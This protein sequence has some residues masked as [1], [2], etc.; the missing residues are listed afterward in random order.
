MKNL[1]QHIYRPFCISVIIGMACSLTALVLCSAALY[2]LQLPV[3]I[4]GIFAAF[5]LTA[6]CFVSGFVLGKQKRKHGLKQGILCGA[7]LFLLCL[8]GGFIFGSITIGGFF[9]R[10][11]LCLCAGMAGGV[12][13][14]N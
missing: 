9:G 2:V 3:E 13:G 1:K 8:S 4:S 7:A 14:V 5:S 6:G 10:L 11:V 12:V